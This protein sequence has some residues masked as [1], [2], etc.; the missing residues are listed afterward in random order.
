MNKQELEM[1]N[2][3]D[4]AFVTQDFETAMNNSKLPYTD[5]KHCKAFRYAASC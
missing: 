2:L 5:F 1:R 4:L 3:I